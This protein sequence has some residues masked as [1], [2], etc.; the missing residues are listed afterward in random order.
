MKP[1][2]AGDGEYLKLEIQIID[3]PAKGR[4]IWH[5]LNLQNKNPTAVNIAKAELSAICRAVNV[6]VPNDSIE[7][8]DIPF[9][10]TLGVQ[11]NKETGDQENRIKKFEARSA[12][13]GAPQA[14]ASTSGSGAAPWAKKAT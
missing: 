10:I 4:K 12:M 5:N 3:G 11:K 6:L 14:S 9:C 7:L 1:T 13:S 2:K 8:H